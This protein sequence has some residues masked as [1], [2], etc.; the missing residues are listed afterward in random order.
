[1]KNNF[2]KGTNVIHCCGDK[3]TFIV[4]ITLKKHFL[5]SNVLPKLP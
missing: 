5:V 2:E 4:L 1:M 3:C